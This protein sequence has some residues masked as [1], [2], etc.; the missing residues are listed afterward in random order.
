MVEDSSQIILHVVLLLLV[1]QLYI[2]YVYLNISEF[3][4]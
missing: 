1:M 4:S 3:V 2:V